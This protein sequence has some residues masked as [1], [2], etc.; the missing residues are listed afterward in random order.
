MSHQIDFKCH[1][2]DDSWNGHWK[3]SEKTWKLIRG[4][5]PYLINRKPYS[6]HLHLLELSGFKLVDNQLVK[7][8][9]N[10]RVKDLAK[11]FQYLSDED[12]RISGAYIIA[13]K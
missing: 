1:G 12:I 7:T 3:F 4:R 10:T 5:R 11:D 6:T 8:E 2:L 9:S 13:K